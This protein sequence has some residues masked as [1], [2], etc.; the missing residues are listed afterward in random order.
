[1]S[2]LRE[3]MQRLGARGVGSASSSSATAAL[4][5]DYERHLPTCSAAMLHYEW[6]WLEQHLETLSLALAQ[7]S[8][9]TTLGGEAK[10]Q[11]MV[12]EGQACRDL[13][14]RRLEELGG[15]PGERHGPVLAGDHA[16]EISHPAIRDHWGLA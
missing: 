11:A 10:V 8:M 12:V 16:W 5:A 14:R 4:L 13:L 7:P 6:A 15:S 2:H 9:L 3:I 1:M